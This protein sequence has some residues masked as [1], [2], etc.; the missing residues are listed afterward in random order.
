MNKKYEK[1]LI[2]KRT[3]LITWIFSKWHI[4]DKK[5]KQPLLKYYKKNHK[6]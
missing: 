5:F 3:C 2:S 1:S 4:F 6:I